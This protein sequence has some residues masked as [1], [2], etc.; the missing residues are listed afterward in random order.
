MR[1][2]KA[3]SSFDALLETPGL[4]VVYI[5]SNH[6]THAAYAVA[7]LRAGLDVYVEKPIA[8]DEVQLTALLLAVEGSRSR[9]FAG[10]NRPFSAAIREL[11]REV[12]IDR[13]RGISLQCFVSGHLIAADHWYRDPGEG[14]RICGNVGHWLDLLVHVLAWRGLPDKLSISLTWA[15]ESE[16]DDNIV[17]AIASDRDDV[18][19]LMLT[20]RCEPFEGISETISFQHADTICVIEDF[21]R[22][23]IWQDTRVV[24]RRYWPKDVGHKAAVLQPFDSASHREWGE[25]ILSTRLMLHITKMVRAREQRSEFALTGG[26]VAPD[27]SQ[28]W[29]G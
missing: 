11:Q 19:S 2:G 14:T 7:A 18:F 6:A 16:P 22:I 5:A 4:R 29:R 26:V 17:I 21:R 20:S 28:G 1:V 3:C 10:Y 24:R 13:S 27:S 9:I 12:T 15:N 8:V 25:V 23:A